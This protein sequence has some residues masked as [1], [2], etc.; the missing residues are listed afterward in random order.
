MNAKI[1]VSLSKDEL[2]ELIRKHFAEKGITPESVSV[3]FHTVT[4]G[5]GTMEH[6]RTEF[7][8]VTVTYT[9]EV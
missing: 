9:A 3:N 1:T 8:D 5:Y 4:E 2:Y 6:D 7:K